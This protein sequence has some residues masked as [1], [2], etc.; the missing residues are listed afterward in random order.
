MNTTDLLLL[1]IVLCPLLGAFANGFLLKKAPRALVYIVALGAIAAPFVAACR[2]LL[3]VGQPTQ[4]SIEVSLFPWLMIPLLD[5]SDF[6]IPFLLRFDHL[7]GMLTLIITGIG[8]LIHLYSIIYMSHEQGVHRFFS[9]LNLFVFAMLCLVLGGNMVV[10][11]LGWEGVGLCSYLLIGYWYQERPNALA[12][13]KAFL[14]NRVGDMGFILAMIL[15][16]VTWGTLD[17][18]QLSEVLSKLPAEWLLANGGLVTGICLALLVAVTG[19]SAQVPLYIW[20]PDAMAGPTPVSALIHAATMVTSGIYLMTRMS[21]LFVLSPSAMHIVAATG[22][23]T[24]LFAATIGVVQTDIKKVLAYSTVSQLGFMVLGCGVGAFQYGVAHLVTHAFFK[25]LLFLGAGSVIH[26]LHHEQDIRKMGGLAKKMPLTASTF[27]IGTAAIIGVPGFSGF[28]SKDEILFAAWTGPFG[29]PIYWIIGACAAALTSFY[30]VRLTVLV[31]FGSFRGEHHGSHAPHENPWQ[32]TVPLVILAFFA[33]FSGYISIPHALS[34]LFTNT[35]SHENVITAWLSPVW[36]SSAQIK[37]NTAFSHAPHDQGVL[38]WVLMGAST[39]I[40]VVASTFAVF[41]Y[42]TGPH[43]AAAFQRALPRLH[44]LVLDKWRIDELYKKVIVDPL[45]R[46]GEYC[47]VV[48]DRF[49]IE[50]LVNDFPRTIKLLATMLSDMQ[51][52]QIRSY[53][54]VFFAGLIVLVLFILNVVLA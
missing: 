10:T 12:G 37:Q 8:F 11:F 33:I 1:C 25:A 27:V 28:F 14:V 31:F 51:S 29:S 18:V 4:G 35:P 22:A 6:S 13:M 7:S 21:G 26:A 49:I 41:L 20:L 5:G 36:D 40:M 50:G 3:I 19:K 34:Q 23:A 24:A 17:Y 43:G 42:R 2:A 48:G 32:M 39:F 47:Y 45:K 9:Y 44:Q 54:K 46:T 52:G 15:C 30:M 38:E 16:Y 53:L